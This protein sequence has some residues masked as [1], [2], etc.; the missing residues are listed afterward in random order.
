MQFMP[1][2]VIKGQAVADFLVDHPVPG[3]SKL[4]DDLPDEV[5]EVN[6]IHVLSEEQVWQ[7]FFDGASR[8]SL[9]G[10][11]I[12]SVGVVLICPHNHVIPRAS[13]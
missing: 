10:N 6:M 5:A 2:K 11:I 7:L 13:H 1:Q 9:E 8:T 4:Y 3:S 12:A